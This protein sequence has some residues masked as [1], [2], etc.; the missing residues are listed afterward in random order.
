WSWHGGDRRLQEL[1]L[2]ALSGEHQLMNAAAAIQVLQAVSD[3]LPASEPAI[4]Q[5]LTSVHLAGRFQYIEGDVPVLLDVAHNPQ[6]VK[7]L[8]DH[9]ALRFQNHRIRA[10]FSIMRDKDIEGVV[11]RIKDRIA[12]W[13]L[14]PLAMAR[15]AS[16]NELMEVMQRLSVSEVRCG[17]PDAARAYAAA[18]SEAQEGD[19]VVIF[20]SF[21]LV[22]ELLAR[23]A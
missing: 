9:L 1:P 23:I 13:Y 4:R 20:G 7:I 18:N 22:S 5:G 8:A 2:P 6:S 10:V 15:A 14:A 11:E 3:R 16:E 12:C 17:F 21:F 19:L